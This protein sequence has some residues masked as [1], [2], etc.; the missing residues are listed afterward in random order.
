MIFIT[1]LRG[2]F[3][4]CFTFLT[5]I[6]IRKMGLKWIRTVA[7]KSHSTVMTYT[8]LCMQVQERIKNRKSGKKGMLVCIGC[9][10][11]VSRMARDAA[12]C[13]GWW[14]AV[15]PLWKT[16]CALCCCH[17]HI[18][19]KKKNRNICRAPR[20]RQFF[21]LFARII[22]SPANRIFQNFILLLL[23]LLYPSGD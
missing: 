13:M 1:Q 10:S 5:T 20:L 14:S 18:S 6:H 11:Q 19:D 9:Y 17:N 15:E 3:L 2:F 4:I 23:K 22:F 7:G 12:A 21:L 16:S 8:I